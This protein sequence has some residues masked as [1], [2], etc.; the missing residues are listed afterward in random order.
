MEW[1]MRKMNMVK[2]TGHNEIPMEFWKST[3]SGYQAAKLYY[4]S[5][6]EG[7]GYEGEEESIYIREPVRIHAPIN[8]RN[9]SSHKEVGGTVKGE[10]KGLAHGVYRS[11]EA[12]YKVPREVLWRC[13]EARGVPVAYIRAIKNMYNGAKSRV[14]AIGGDSGYFPVMVGLHQD[15]SLARSCSPWRWMY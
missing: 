14:R 9:H 12:Y 2:A 15:Q 6:G 11:R 4:K 10:K 3:G 5:L 7:G 1:A 13:L 8:H